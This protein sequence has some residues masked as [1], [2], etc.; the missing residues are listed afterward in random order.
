[1]L[2]FYINDL[3]YMAVEFNSSLVAIDLTEM[4]LDTITDTILSLPEMYA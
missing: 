3:G 4:D 2:K 1:M